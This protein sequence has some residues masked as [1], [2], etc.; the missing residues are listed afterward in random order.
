VKIEE[1]RA[2]DLG[3]FFFG[4][5]RKKNGR[6]AAIFFAALPQKR[7]SASIPR[8]AQG[9][10][11][12]GKTANHASIRDAWAADRFALPTRGFAHGLLVRP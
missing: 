3:A 10:P 5:R 4:A 7:I 9:L 12:K 8:A 1:S 11:K 6:S 2:G